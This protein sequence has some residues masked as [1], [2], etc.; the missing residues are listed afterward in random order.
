MLFTARTIAGAVRRG[1]TSVIGSIPSSAA[2]RIGG[3]RPDAEQATVAIKP[4]DS[5][6]SDVV[7]RLPG[8][9]LL[10]LGAGHYPGQS[11]RPENLPQHP[12][13]YGTERRDDRRR[14][15]HA[16]GARQCLGPVFGSRGSHPRRHRRPRRS[17]RQTARYPSRHPAGNRNR[18]PCRFRYTPHPDYRRTGRD[19]P[20]TETRPRSGNR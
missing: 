13:A 14:G 9:G 7:R 10:R 1:S 19:R 20:A 2:S 17:H 4:L 15:L 11:H 16:H 8:V 12:G 5:R 3:R 6:Q 18:P